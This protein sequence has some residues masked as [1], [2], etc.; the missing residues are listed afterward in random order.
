MKVPRKFFSKKKK[1]F[2]RVLLSE[3]SIWPSHV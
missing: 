1:C 3:C 2:D